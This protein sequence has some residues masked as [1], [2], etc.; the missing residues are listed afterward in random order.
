VYL[1][2]IC[3]YIV[4]A[5]FFV[6]IHLYISIISMLLFN[7][8]LLIFILVYVFLLLCMFCSVYSVFIV[9][10][11][12]LPVPLLRFFRVFSSVVTMVQLAKTGHGPYSSKINCVILCTVCV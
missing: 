2:L 10:N 1:Y 6:L 3:F 11:G 12:T 8:M 5:G 7:F 4:C 9:P